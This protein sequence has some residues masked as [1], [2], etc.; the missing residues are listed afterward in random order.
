M[1]KNHTAPIAASGFD[2]RH[3]FA[4]HPRHPDSGGADG[5][6]GFRDAISDVF[7][8]TVVQTSIVH[9]I[10]DSLQFVSW[11]ER[12]RLMRALR[13]IYHATSAGAA[14]VA[15]ELFALDRLLSVR[16]GLL[17]WRRDSCSVARP[18]SRSRGGLYACVLR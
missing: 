6:T 2:Q 9:L 12:T 1:A 17:A 4:R 16:G 7:P 14:A 13:H 15:V 18:L 10:R 5:S 8:N 11:A 3:Q